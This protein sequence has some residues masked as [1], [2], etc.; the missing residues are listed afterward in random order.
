M[1]RDEILAEAA[2][3]INT[4]RAAVYG[5]NRT[6]HERIAKLWSVVLGIDVQTWQVPLCMNQLKV[7]RLI[8]TPTH[9]DG[10]IDGTGYMALGGEIATEEPCAASGDSST[11][12]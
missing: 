1:N 12:V 6:N 10:W 7:A 5:D 9:P 8:Q 3:L 4:D 11:S 2:R